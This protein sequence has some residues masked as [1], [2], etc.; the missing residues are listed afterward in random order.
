MTELIIISDTTMFAFKR[1]MKDEEELRNLEL[2][3]KR[4]QVYEEHYHSLW[5]ALDRLG[6]VSDAKEAHLLYTTQQWETKRYTGYVERARKRIQANVIA[7]E[8]RGD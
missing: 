6:F 5:L 1:L 4:S 2:T 7:Q 3:L 8:N